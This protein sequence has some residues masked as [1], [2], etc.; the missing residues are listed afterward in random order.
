MEAQLSFS[1][2][3]GEDSMGT[4]FTRGKTWCINF[5][6]PDGQQVRRAVSEYKEVAETALKKVEMDIILG[7]YCD[8]KKV[9]SVLFEAFVDEF[10]CNYVNLENRHPHRQMS[11]INIIKQHFS[12]LPLAK[13]DTR[14]IRQF[15][16]EKL[17]VNK[18]A[19]V[20][21]YL[22]MLRCMFNRGREWKI[23]DGE[24]PTDGIKKLPE[25]NERIRWLSNEEQTLLLSHCQGL[26][27]VI[28]LTALQTGLRWN[29]IMSLKWSRCDKSNYVD[30]DH[31]VVVVHSAQSKSK[32]SRFIP[33]SY[34]LQCALFDL[35]KTS[36]SEYVFTNP[37]TGRPFNN[38]RKS[39]ARA[40]K[41]A[42]L[43]DLTP[44]S[45]RH[46][47]ASSL[48]E[49]GTDLYVVQQL[50]GHSTPKMTQRYA[51]IQPDQFK[52]AIKEIDLQFADHQGLK[53]HP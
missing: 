48:V 14:M 19:T 41:G 35:R 36:Q 10:V 12:G 38:I 27:R 31:N 21:R 6:D 45:C 17:K 52:T 46:V 23:F 39:F 42:G 32:K 25:G 8:Q 24:N 47:F 3:K 49:K 7:R 20:N 34:S 4:L 30:F 29:E 22:S 33:M 50:L 18:P 28:V 43:K 51:H 11:R 40:V 44:H 2:E 13:I 37:Q 53:A 26:T 9:Q 5:I 15:L 1:Q 16:A